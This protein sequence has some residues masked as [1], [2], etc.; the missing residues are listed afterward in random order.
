MV[1]SVFPGLRDLQDGSVKRGPGYVVGKLKSQHNVFTYLESSAL[2]ARF[3]SLP[4]VFS[5]IKNE[6]WKPERER[7]S[8]NQG[9]QNGSEFNVFQNLADA[10]DVFS[11][12][13]HTIRT[14][15]EEAIK[16]TA[17]ESI[18]KD[19]MFD[20]VGDYIDIGRFLDG[21]PEC[22]GVAYQ[23][24]PAGLYTTILINLSAV[25]HV[26]AE[27]MNHRQARILR[28]VDWMESQGVRCQIR[29][30]VSSQ[31]A[32]VDVTVKDFDQAVNMNDLAVTSHSEFLRRIG[33]LIDEQSDTWTW[34]YGSPRDFTRSM[35]RNYKAIPED[36]LTVFVGD[37]S[38]SHL[39]DIDKEFDKL[40]DK[41]AVLI[42]S[43][44]SR[45][46]SKVYSVE[47]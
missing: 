7:S 29:A 40:R 8:N 27:A 37:Q 28:L 13:P 47:L 17:E 43:P 16:L 42:E 4:A 9:G 19:V 18:G 25:Y 34:G 1:V 45:D 5:A 36:G 15:K 39:E 6:Q 2:I 22:F 44:Q 32:H 12:R 31:C 11:N 21:E 23:G 41:I 33:F 26:T 14:F 3:D 46:F 38:H 30:F 20:V 24:N 10:I 35:T